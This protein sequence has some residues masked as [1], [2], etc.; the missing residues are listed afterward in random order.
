MQFLHSGYKTFQEKMA[1]YDVCLRILDFIEHNVENW[2]WGV[3]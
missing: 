1:F 2:I 3:S